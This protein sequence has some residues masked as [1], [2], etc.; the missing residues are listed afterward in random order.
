MLDPGQ[1]K[2]GVVAANAMSLPALVAEH[3]VEPAAHSGGGAGPFAAPTTA[4]ARSSP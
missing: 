1:E 4:V 3:D 2:L